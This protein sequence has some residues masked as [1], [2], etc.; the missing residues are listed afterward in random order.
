[1]KRL[2]VREELEDIV[3]F[4]I[5]LDILEHKIQAIKQQY[6]EYE[7]LRIEEISDGDYGYDNFVIVGDR[8]ETDKERD[9]RMKKAEKEKTETEK[10]EAKHRDYI[11]SEAKKLKLS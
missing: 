2:L 9:R 6:A 10:R 8:L 5:S 11:L 3:L 4:N 1:M 7:N